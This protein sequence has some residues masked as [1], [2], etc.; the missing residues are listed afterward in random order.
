MISWKVLRLLSI[1]SFISALCMWAGFGLS[2]YTDLPLAVL[3]TQC[4]LGT[5][6]TLFGFYYRR[7]GL[8]AKNFQEVFDRIDKAIMAQS[9]IP[10]VDVKPTAGSSLTEDDVKKLLEIIHS[11][12]DDDTLN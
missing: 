2:L 5:A 9:E 11:Q 6:A 1:L 12:K 3:L 8:I 10:S 4:C 7:E